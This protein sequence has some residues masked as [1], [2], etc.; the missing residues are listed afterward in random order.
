MD[1]GASSA[2]AD[3]HGDAPF[4]LEQFELIAREPLKRAA[5]RVR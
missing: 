5:I 3:L 1:G 2:Q 4:R